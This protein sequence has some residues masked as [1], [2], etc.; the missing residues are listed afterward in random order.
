MF[1]TLF[2]SVRV[3][4]QDEFVLLQ[5]DLRKTGWIFFVILRKYLKAA[6]FF[7]LL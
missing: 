1:F 4:S 7:K 2:Q 6:I 3:S 5:H